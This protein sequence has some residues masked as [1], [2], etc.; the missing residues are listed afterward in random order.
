MAHPSTGSRPDGDPTHRLVRRGLT[1][2]EAVA[3][4]TPGPGR[5]AGH[6]ERAVG[7][8]PGRQTFAAMANRDFRLLWLAT[9]GTGAGWW[10]DTVTRGW[11]I[12]QLTGSATQ[13]G[14]VS[15][16]RAVPFLAFGVFAGVAADRWN[17]QMQLQISQAIAIASNL[18]MALLVVT[19]WVQVWHVYVAAI[20]TGASQAFMQPARQ[21]L[22][23]ALVPRGELMN[24]IALSSGAFS[25]TKSVGPALGGALVAAVGVVG[26]YVVQ[27]G[28]YL[29]AAT[30]LTRMD[31]PDTPSGRGA[32]RSV[33]GDLRAGLAYARGDAVILTL[34]LLALIPA[35]LGSPYYFLLPMIADRVLS[36][37]PTGLGLL[38]AAPGIGSMVAVTA[39]AIAGDFRRKG[40]VMLAGAVTFGIALVL[41]SE[42]RWLPL[43]CLLLGVVGCAQSGYNAINMTLLQKLVPDEFR[44]R[45][46]SLLLL[47]RGMVPLGAAAIGVLGDAWGAPQAVLCMGALCALVAAVASLRMPHVRALQ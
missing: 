8:L 40:T 42:S 23:P 27:A 17:R 6:G 14:L 25:I 44:G 30:S 29:W 33:L 18:A 31:T 3:I 36:V 26:T 1:G 43:S 34:L 9:L 20:V 7:G 32:K 10:M 12:Y 37:G 28:V 5:D 41:F 39:L 38:A 19:G 35:V 13:L 16:V 21:S 15:A 24:A 2:I 46:I 22:I 45:V 47:D 4:A 11:L